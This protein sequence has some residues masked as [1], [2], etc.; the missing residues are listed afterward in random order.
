[1]TVDNIAERIGAM[2]LGEFSAVPFKTGLLEGIPTLPRSV[3]LEE[4]D[5]H[6]FVHVHD[7]DPKYRQILT[8]EVKRAIGGDAGQTD[9]QFENCIT[10]TYQIEGEDDAAIDA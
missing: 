6:A 5:G 8:R 7:T 3:Y 4:S 10:L 2:Q 9:E 1:M